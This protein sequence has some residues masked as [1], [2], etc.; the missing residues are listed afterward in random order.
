MLGENSIEI[1]K[2]WELSG[3]SPFMSCCRRKG[4]SF[5]SGILGTSPDGT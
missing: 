1:K 2:K 3:D 4:E 5:L